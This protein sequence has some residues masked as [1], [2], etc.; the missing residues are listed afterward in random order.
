[1]DSLPNF[2]MIGAQRCG[3]TTF[4]NSLISHPGVAKA[5]RKE[6]HY[7][8]LRFDRG[9]SWYE[10]MFVTK[11][12]RISGEAS[13]YYMCL[14][15]V[16]ERIWQTAPLVKLVAMVRNPVDR[17]FGHFQHEKRAGFETRTFED[18]IAEEAAT[19]GDYERELWMAKN[20][21]WPDHNHFSYQTRGYYAQQLKWYLDVFPK[22]QLHV[23][24]SEDYFADPA[25]QLALAV[26]YLGLSK[27]ELQVR[28]KPEAKYQD[29]MKVETREY[30]VDH[31]RPH[32]AA[33]EELLGRDFRWDK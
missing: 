27:Q 15:Y 13:P 33:L 20:A 22:E 21:F 30:L 32:N 2:I 31:F 5:V 12:G 17:A 3:T 19:L 26:E 28:Q 29:T 4:Y 11:R 7:F 18:A 8:D 25:G 6:V 16:P 23:I 9:R 1:M 14:P 24:R 10:Q